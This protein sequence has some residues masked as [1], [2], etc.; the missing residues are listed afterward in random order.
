MLRIILISI[1]LA[2]PAT[3]GPVVDQEVFGRTLGG[4]TAD[5]GK[6]AD[7]EVSGSRYRTYRPEVSPTPNGGIFVSLRIDHRRGWMASPDT[8]SLE[9]SFHP[10]GTLE[11]AQ[12]SLGFQGRRITSDV[13]R[14]GGAA[15]K[16]LA[17]P[18]ID[19]AVKIGTDLVADLSSK[20]LRE[21]IVE[22]G[23]V[24][25][26]AA[27]RHNFNLV[28]AAVRIEPAGDS[29][30]PPPDNDKNQINLP[31]KPPEDPKEKPDVATPPLEIRPFGK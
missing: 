24:T 9:L 8:A 6:A 5:S 25:F 7:Y 16:G 27:I 3:A 20:L 12:S 31:A 28:F 23:R 2:A 11:S 17:G 18:G 30:P 13:I 4:W 14:S 19:H 21:K 29:A 22:P 15:G 10:D 1:A 26:P